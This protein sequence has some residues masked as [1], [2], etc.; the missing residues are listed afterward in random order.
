MDGGHYARTFDE[1]ELARMRQTMDLLR[2]PPRRISIG[3]G[4]STLTVTD[5]SGTESTWRIDKRWVRQKVEG[6]GDLETMARWNGED[7]V[8]E[9]KVDGG[10][11]ITATCRLGLG[12]SRLVVFVDV[13]G[14]PQPLALRWLYDPADS[15][16]TAPDGR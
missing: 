7:L 8:I 15:A 11:R 14:L 12:G 4:D 9:R 1:K 10:G 2:D 16:G 13:A 6:G 3:A 5:R